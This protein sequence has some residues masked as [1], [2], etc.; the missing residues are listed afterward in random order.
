MSRIWGCGVARFE[1]IVPNWMKLT[2]P[3]FWFTTRAMFE[4]GSIATAL[5]LLPT[6][7]CDCGRICFDWRSKSVAVPLEFTATPMLVK[8][9][10][11]AATYPVVF[12]L[13]VLT[14]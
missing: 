6:V 9:F 10:M 14:L 4:V 11:A 2:V 8:G 1:R 3:S 5:G 13:I 7:N 12:V